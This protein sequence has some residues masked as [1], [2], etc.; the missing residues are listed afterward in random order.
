METKM[1]K[2]S[3]KYLHDMSLIYKSFANDKVYYPA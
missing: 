3:K 2:K 1:G